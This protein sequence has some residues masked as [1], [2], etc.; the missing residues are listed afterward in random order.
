MF[1]TRILLPALLLAGGLFFAG[2]TAEARPYHV[3]YAP[4]CAP[5]IVVAPCPAPVCAP[6]VT[7]GHYRV[8]RPVYYRGH[9][10]HR[11]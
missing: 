3:R 5:P 8:A 7:Y 6:V 9:Y 1:R 2:S 4:V 11:R 10:I